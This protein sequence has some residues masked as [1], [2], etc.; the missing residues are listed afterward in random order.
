MAA[1]EY[2]G[3]VVVRV[4][5]GVIHWPHCSWGDGAFKVNDWELFPNYQLAVEAGYRPCGNCL[6]SEAER[7]RDG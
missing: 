6:W 7:E 5:T 1:R 4:S 2:H 3:G